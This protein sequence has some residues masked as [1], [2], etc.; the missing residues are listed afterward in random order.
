MIKVYTIYD[1]KA[2]SYS[3]TVFTASTGD[4]AVRIMA[5]TLVQDKMMFTYAPDFDLYLIGEFD[6]ETGKIVSLLNPQ[7]IINL[8][9]IRSDLEKMENEQNDKSA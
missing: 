9:S 5:M 7:H 2:Q 6:S 3:D 8:Q 4:I 1:K